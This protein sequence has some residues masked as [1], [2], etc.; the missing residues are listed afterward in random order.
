MFL[1]PR[2]GKVTQN[3]DRRANRCNLL[4]GESA[5]RFA[6]LHERLRILDR[7]SPHRNLRQPLL[8]L[9]EV[10]HRALDADPKSRRMVR[11]ME[12]HEL[13]DCVPS[14]ELGFK[15]ALTGHVGS[16][17]EGWNKSVLTLRRLINRR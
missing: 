15:R 16:M 9:R 2:L 7:H 13:V 12:V 11:L 10:G 1:R 14:T 4:L 5:V 17:P 8:P 6:A 3:M